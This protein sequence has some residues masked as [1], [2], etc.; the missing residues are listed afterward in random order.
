MIWCKHGLQDGKTHL[1]ISLCYG[2][3]FK[4]YDLAKLLKLVPANREL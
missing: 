3:D 4:S 1:D 2:K